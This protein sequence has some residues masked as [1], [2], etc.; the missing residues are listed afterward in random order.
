MQSQ[1]YQQLNPLALAIAAGATWLLGS[2]LFG[3]TMM[4]I[5]GGP[6]MM[7][8]YGHGSA[9]ALSAM[10]WIGALL[11]AFGGALFAWIYNALN[12]KC[13]AGRDAAEPGSGLPS[14]GIKS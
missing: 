10:W 12:A 2:L 14:V 1:W 4:G 13:I 6:W 3:F 9:M 5:M 7:G 11:A 8:V